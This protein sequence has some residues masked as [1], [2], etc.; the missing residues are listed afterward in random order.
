VEY[1]L[2]NC[3]IFRDQLT[4]QWADDQLLSSEEFGLGGSYIGRAY[5][6]SEISGDHGVGSLIELRYGRDV[7]NKVLR[8]YQLYGFYD[9]GAV[10]NDGDGEADRQTLASAGAGVR[11]AL[12]GSLRINLEYARALTRPVSQDGDKIERLFLSVTFDY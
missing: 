2:N 9:I 5:D 10:W 11:M 3:P 12:P 6:F 1:T 8:G 7:E 4:G